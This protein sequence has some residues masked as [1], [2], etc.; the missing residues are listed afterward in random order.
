MLIVTVFVPTVPSAILTV[1]SLPAKPVDNASKVMLVPMA[2]VAV[3][4]LAPPVPLAKVVGDANVGAAVLAPA[5]PVT[6]REP[7]LIA[8]AKLVQKALVPLPAMLS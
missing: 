7:L 1:I 4:F 2:A 6:N 8:V 5:V 3:K